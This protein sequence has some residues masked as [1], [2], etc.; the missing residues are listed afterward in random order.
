MGNY[1]NTLLIS[2]R[3]CAHTHTHTS[4]SVSVSIRSPEIEEKM[5]IKSL[6]SKFLSLMDTTHILT[7]TVTFIAFSL[8]TH[9]ELTTR[10]HP[11]RVC[12]CE[13]TM[14]GSRPIDVYVCVQVCIPVLHRSK[15]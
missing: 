3:A 13:T 5:G 8:K 11:K 14:H 7:L 6:V 10:C 4:A 2:K 9:P 12:V 15:S 1:R